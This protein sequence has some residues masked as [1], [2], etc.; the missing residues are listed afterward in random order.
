MS[1][2][3]HDDA[4]TPPAKRRLGPI[5]VVVLLVAVVLGLWLAWRSP[6]DQIQGM[7]DADTINVAAKI[8]ARVAEL[9][10]R[11][12]DRVQPG[13]VLFLLDSPEV[14]AKE[15]QAHGALAAAQAVADKADEGARSEDIRAAEANWKRAEAGA[16]L[17]EATYQR[18]Q[19]LFNE[20]VMTRQKRDEAH[21]QATSSRELARAARAQYD[22]ALAGAREQDKRAAQGQVQQAQG[23]VAE[24]NAARAEVEGRAPVAGEI[25][26]RM[27]DPGELVPAGYPVFTLVDIDRMWVAMNLRES[28]MQGLKVGSKLQGNVPALGLDGEFE[29]YFINP[30]GDYA[31]WRTTRQSSGYDV[32]SFEVRVR[33]VRRIEGFRPGMSVLFA[34]PQH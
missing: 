5:L 3:L 14:A 28:Q 23:A 2:V 15:Q 32:R 13:Q 25:N 16:T 24:V 21:A 12:G 4:T 30:A 1:D 6:A 27:A 11:E 34:W 33:P 22:M 19:N 10:V 7:A 20:G 17:A 26:K 9:K 18:V 8:T 31:T 29:V